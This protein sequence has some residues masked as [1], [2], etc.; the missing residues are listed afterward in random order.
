VPD[1]AGEP[2]PAKPPAAAED[3]HIDWLPAGSWILYDLANTIYAAAITYVLMPYFS[4]TYKYYTPIGVTQTLTMIASGFAV[5]MMASICDRTGQTRLYLTIFTL[6]CI[7]SMFGWALWTTEFALLAFLAIGGFAYQNSLVFYNA[8]LPS[9]APRSRTGLI[10]GLGVGLGYSGTIVTILIALLLTKYFNLGFKATCGV[11]AALFLLTAVPCLLFVKEKRHIDRQPLSWAVVRERG[12]DL[13]GTIR[14]MPQ[15]RTVMFFFLGNFFL[16]DVLNTAILYFAAF[17]QVIFKA[18][19]EAGDLFLFGQQF[20]Q[21][22]TFAMIMG[23]ALCSLALVF[24]SFSGWLSDRIHPLQVLRGSGWCLLVGL[25][26][27]I[28]TGGKS[29]ALYLLTLGG[30]GAFGLAGIWTSGRKVL[31]LVAPQKDIAQYFGL[32]GI[33]LKLSVIGS[34]TF[35]LVSDTIFKSEKAKLGFEVAQTKAQEI[36]VDLAQ[37]HSQKVAIACQL[38]QL[39]VGLGLLYAIK[40]RDIPDQDLDDVIAAGIPAA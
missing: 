2:T 23:L 7:G 28:L 8:L 11:C 14:A 18:Q 22:S 19:A 38:I 36:A 37:S 24:G 15:H 39:L 5:P 20:D 30:A 25:V 9:V 10:S 27:A 4:D 21:S 32:Y 1:A 29:P 6:V 35:A 34:T 16:V 17:T 12:A 26:G 13:W 33:T 31:L 40:W 3:R